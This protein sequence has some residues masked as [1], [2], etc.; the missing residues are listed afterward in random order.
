MRGS[1]VMH[2]PVLHILLGHRVRLGGSTGGLRAWRESG[3]NTGDI[4]AELLE[5]GIIHSDAG[6]DGVAGVGDHERVVDRLAGIGFLVPV[7][8][9]QERRLHQI[10]AR[11]RG[12]I[13]RD[14]HLVLGRLR[15]L[16]ITRGTLRHLTGRG[17][18]VHDR[19]RR[20]VGLGD[21][22]L[23]R[24]TLGRETGQQRPCGAG[25]LDLQLIE[26]RI[27]DRD[28]FER[29]VAGVLHLERPL[30]DVARIIDAVLVCVS[31]QHVALVERH[32]RGRGRIGRDLHLVGRRHR[33]FGITRSAVGHLTGRSRDIYDR[34]SLGVGLGDGVLARLAHHH[35]F[36]CEGCRVAGHFDPELVELGIV[37]HDIV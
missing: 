27:V 25:H 14:L 35:S 28:L 17:R 32:G 36:R 9:V 16:R 22:V 24:L 21:G 19:T 23:A 3:R 11:G 10:Q 15:I 26:L 30:H 1:H 29:H 8:I 34:T 5:H 33:I 31:D 4:D 13:G 37:H 18:D 2:L 12:R 20:S 7:L 6:E